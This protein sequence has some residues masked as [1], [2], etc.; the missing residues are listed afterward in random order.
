MVTQ[1][2]NNNYLRLWHNNNFVSPQIYF[3]CSIFE[4][5][6]GKNGIVSIAYTPVLFTGTNRFIGNTGTDSLKV[7]FQVTV[8]YTIYYYYYFV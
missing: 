3:I 6:N 1:F 5:N 4:Q 2:V 7:S 8:Y